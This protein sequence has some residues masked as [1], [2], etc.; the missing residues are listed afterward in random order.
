MIN[1]DGKELAMAA[2]HAYAHYIVKDIQEKIRFDGLMQK[3]KECRDFIYSKDT[4]E[5]VYK[6]LNEEPRYYMVRETLISENEL[7][8]FA[9]GNSEPWECFV[10]DFKRTGRA[11]LAMIA[12]PQCYGFVP[13][14]EAPYYKSYITSDD[15]GIVELSECEYNHFK[16]WLDYA[17]HYE[18]INK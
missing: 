18:E 11:A 8:T 10:N 16:T 2:V 6:L 15:K 4:V 7:W 1:I 5:R 3:T 13:K 14:Q 9:C 12:P 17:K